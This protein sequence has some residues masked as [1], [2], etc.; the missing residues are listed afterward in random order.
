[1]VAPKHYLWG[2]TQKLHP[3]YRI[4]ALAGVPT[5]TAFHEAIASQHD[6]LSYTGPL[7][8]WPAHTPIH[9]STVRSTLGNAAAEGDTY[10]ALARS[11]TSDA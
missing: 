7:A 5:A 6:D 11:C 2:P 4:F 8:S 3:L 1:M 10:A 9:G